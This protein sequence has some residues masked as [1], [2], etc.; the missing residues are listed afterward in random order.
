MIAP[1]PNK[2][3]MLTFILNNYSNTRLLCMCVLVSHL[4]ISFGAESHYGFNQPFHHRKDVAQGQ[5]LSKV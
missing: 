1:P 4:Y 5:F 2:L 3:Q